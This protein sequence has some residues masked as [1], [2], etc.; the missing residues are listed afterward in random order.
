MDG[1]KVKPSAGN[2]GDTLEHVKEN[3]SGMADEVK[4]KGEA[5]LQKAQTQGR[6]YFDDAQDS[7]IRAW[8]DL[9]ILVKK[10]QGPAIATAIVAS[11]LFYAVHRFNKD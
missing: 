1:L 3:L 6:E 10:H 7:G 5:F 4:A 2:G 9:K 8:K 11:L